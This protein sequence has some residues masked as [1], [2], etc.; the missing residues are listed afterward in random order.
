[1]TRA[2]YA[3]SVAH[4]HRACMA[5]KLQRAH[6]E[7]AALDVNSMGLKAIAAQPKSVVTVLESTEARETKSVYL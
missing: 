4:F 7:A 3:K 5:L 6:H 1:M 2:V